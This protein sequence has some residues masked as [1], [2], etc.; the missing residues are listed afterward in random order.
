MDSLKTGKKTPSGSALIQHRFWLSALYSPFR[1]MTPDIQREE[2]G[3]IPR[4]FLVLQ[5]IGS[6][7]FIAGL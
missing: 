5:I 3:I 2:G 7:L 1:V 4:L 6:G